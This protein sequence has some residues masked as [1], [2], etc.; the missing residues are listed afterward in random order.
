MALRSPKGEYN[1]KFSTYS[2]ISSMGNGFTFALESAIFAAISYGVQME[3]DGEYSADDSA[4]YGDDIIVKTTLVDKMVYALNSCGFSLNREKS[5][6]SGPFRESCGA[7]WFHGQ[8]IRPVLLSE[9]PQSVPAVI[10]DYNRLKRILELRWDVK[11][12]KTCSQIYKHIPIHFHGMNGPLSDEE[13]DTYMHTSIPYSRYEAGLWTF[14][15][16]TVRSINRRFPK[17]GFLFGKLMDD[18]RIN[19]TSQDKWNSRYVRG[20]RLNA[21]GSKFSLTDNRSVKASINISAVSNWQSE[22]REVNPQWR[23]A[24][25][26]N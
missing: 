12:S 8:H 10:N 15:R 18:L 13:F 2:K 22:Y 23:R 17:T 16:L 4:I 20:V 5:F 3:V 14:P 24:A 6:T 9:T 7:D 26:I 11:E 21:D 19:S 1:G 25:S